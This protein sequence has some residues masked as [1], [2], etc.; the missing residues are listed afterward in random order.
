MFEYDIFFGP[1]TISLISTKN[2]PTAA[3]ID[4]PGL[5]ALFT[6]SATTGVVVDPH[7]ANDDI[8][9]TK[10][11]EVKLSELQNAYLRFI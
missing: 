7:D 8:Q 11:R 9:K 1:N 5:P 10:T 6:A 3:T 2:D 4:C